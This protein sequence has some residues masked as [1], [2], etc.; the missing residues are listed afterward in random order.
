MLFQIV[1]KNLIIPIS[2]WNAARFL[3]DTSYLCLL[4]S[5]RKHEIIVLYTLMLLSLADIQPVKTLDEKWLVFG[6]TFS[7]K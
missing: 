7:F 4:N 1:L 5:I 2:D 6:L 3:K